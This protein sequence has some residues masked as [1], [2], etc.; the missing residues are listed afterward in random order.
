MTWSAHRVLWTCGSFRHEHDA[1]QLATEPDV[2]IRA[3]GLPGLLWH[4]LPCTPLLGAS[5]DCR[6]GAHVFD[7]FA[8]SI[9][10]VCSIA[11]CPPRPLDETVGH[12]PV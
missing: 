10:A 8:V 5:L 12:V 11:I 1:S 9:V 3:G 2:C 7:A 4:A 6:D